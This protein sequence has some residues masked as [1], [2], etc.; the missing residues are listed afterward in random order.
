MGLPMWLSAYASD[1]RSLSITIG[2]WV[3]TF[4]KCGYKGSTGSQQP[5]R[6]PKQSEF[7]STL[8]TTSTIFMWSPSQNHKKRP[9][10]GRLKLAL[11][12]TSLWNHRAL[13]QHW[14]KSEEFLSLG[15]TQDGWI[16]LDLCEKNQRIVTDFKSFPVLRKGSAILNKL[17][18]VKGVR[19]TGAAWTKWQYVSQTNKLRH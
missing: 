15:H 19:E 18:R 3:P 4:S 16:M 10:Q 8:L 6:R 12:W 2:E 17:P 1:G 5:V 7:I 11:W 9:E 14:F 13:C